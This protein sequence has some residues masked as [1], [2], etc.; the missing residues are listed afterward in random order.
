MES[1]SFI[2]FAILLVLLAFFA[3]TEI[4]LMSVSA[5]KLDSFLKQGRFGSVMLKRILHN[6]ERLLV[7]NLI[8][9][10]IVTIA[11]SSLSTVVAIKA[12]EEFG[13]SGQHAVGIAIVA[14]STIILL[15]GEIAPK[16][17]GVRYTDS[18][19]LG[20]AP[21]Y[22]FLMIVLT[23][24][25]FL[26]EF[27]IRFLNLLTGGKVDIHSHKIS[28]EELEAFI[29][30]SHEKGAVDSQEHRKIMGVLDLDDMEA[31]SVMTPRVDVDFARLDM[32]VDEICQL[33]LDSSHSRLPVYGETVD[34]VEYVITFREAFAMK[35]A[36]KG[37]QPLSDFRLEKIIRV[38]L[39]QP[40]D[41][42]FSIF[43]KSR[44][45]IAV[46]IDE[47]G[48]T[49]GVITM[50]DIVEE[51]FGDIKDEKDRE[52]VYMTK[53]GDGRIRIQSSVLINDVI[54]ELEIEEIE[55]IGLDES[56]LGETISYVLMSTLER[57]PTVGEVVTLQGKR[58]TLILEVEGVDDGMAETIVARL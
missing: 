19:A 45:H 36:G 20:V 37:A 39:T 38:P 55:D 13:F 31:E 15:F 3:G 41:R 29:D 58:K 4:P 56:Y 2:G 28:S 10:T 16:I 23:P 12:A 11:I 32:T 50:E 53:L 26:I 48:G 54:E 43:Q 40:L 34:D 1:A 44:K 42:V 52:A 57:F 22:R 33:F 30:L 46:V 18:V 47:H 49:A 51:V 7:V 8:G 35:S 9:T 14:A 24:I 21:I 5:H 25:N 17:I 27:F 6:S